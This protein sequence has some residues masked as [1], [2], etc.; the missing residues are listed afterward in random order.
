MVQ[1][2]ERDE[3]KFQFGDKEDVFSVAGVLKQCKLTVFSLQVL[4]D[5]QIYVNCQNQCSLSH[6]PK[7]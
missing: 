5:R 6:M 4:A 7:G 3:T 2:V 1:D